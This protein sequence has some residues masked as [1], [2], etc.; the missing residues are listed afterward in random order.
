MEMPITRRD[1]S[2]R[3]LA[4]A[5]LGVTPPMATARAGESASGDGMAGLPP[6]WYGSETIAFLAYPGFVSLDLTGPFHMLGS[7]LGS[8][9]FVV[10]KSREPVVADLKLRIMP[11]HTFDSCPADLDIICVPGGGEGT[12]DAMRDEA[13]IR[14]LKD[15]GAR[16]RFV[17]SVCTGSLVLAA[18]GLLQGYRA[19]SHWLARDLLAGF[20]AE[21]VD[22]RVVV[23]RNRITGAG[24]TAG[25]DMGLG[26]VGRLRDLQYAETVQ[27]L[28]EYAP[29]PPYHAGTPA[30][31]SP[32]NVEL[33]RSMFVSFT[34]TVRAVAANYRSVEK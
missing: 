18:A 26:L 23:A 32:E 17:T 2:A 16:A 22:A 33:C 27:L 15:R 3:A 12:L 9:P 19:T 20:G 25:L 14:F 6:S 7:L 28:A 29:E 30:T 24:V 11:D 1:L 21:P 34:N 13:T 5:I 4:M 8:T 10:A 31:A